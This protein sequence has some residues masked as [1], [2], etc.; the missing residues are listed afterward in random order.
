MQPSEKKDRLLALF[1]TLLI[2]GLLLLFLIF[3]M[4]QTPI[5]PYPPSVYTEVQID[6]EGGG[7]ADGAEGS[8]NPIASTTNKAA[9]ISSSSPEDIATNSLD[10]PTIEVKKPKKK[11]KKHPV[12][13]PKETASEQQDPQP[14][15]ELKALISSVHDKLSK[16]SGSASNADGNGKATS[17]NGLGKGNSQGSGEGN[18]VGPGKGNGYVLKGRKLL[19]RPE[20]LD[21]SQE[22][23]AVVV[24]IT[25]D[26]TGRVIEAIPGQRGSTTTSAYL[27]TLARQAAKTAR[28]SPSTD[29][30]KEQT[31]T[32]TFVFRLN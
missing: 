21:N 9:S 18:G 29:G 27:F 10:E 31:G 17:G 19:K 16:S 13:T 11:P 20:L 24:A 23:G 8:G 12:D 28:F 30:S 26:E 5:P 15:D 14:S 32:Y 6:F 3:F 2:T 25:V 4:I 1:I 22:E 7:G